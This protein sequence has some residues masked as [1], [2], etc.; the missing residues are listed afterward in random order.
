MQTVYCSSAV[1]ELTFTGT[2]SP[3]DQ[4]RKASEI[5]SK[6]EPMHERTPKTY[7]IMIETYPR[8]CQSNHSIRKLL[9]M[10]FVVVTRPKLTR[11][12]RRKRIPSVL[13]TNEVDRFDDVPKNRTVKNV[14][15]I[16]YGLSS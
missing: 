7:T 4:L 14:G 5:C 1:V 16:R 15:T 2:R 3:V 8:A 12:F 10:L 9:F 11:E 6:V 13:V